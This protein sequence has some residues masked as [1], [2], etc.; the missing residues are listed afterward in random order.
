MLCFTPCF[1]YLTSSAVHS[2][3][4]HPVYSCIVFHGV[5]IISQAPLIDSYDTLIFY[6]YKLL[7]YLIIHTHT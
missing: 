6:Y 5:D 7:S 4:V 3:V 2:Q 1:L